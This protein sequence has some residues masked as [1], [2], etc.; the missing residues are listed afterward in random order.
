[1]TAEPKKLSKKQAKVLKALEKGKTP[2]QVATSMKINVNGVYQHM[3]RLEEKGYDV[4][5][6]GRGNT[7]RRAAPEKD[8]IDELL[9]AAPKVESNGHDARDL[10]RKGIVEVIQI[11]SDR[12]K[13]L[14]VEIT[15]LHAKKVDLEQQ[16]ERI[17]DELTKLGGIGIDLT[18]R[19]TD[20]EEI[21]AK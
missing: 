18:S 21:L 6:V 11:A 4:P 9:A 14:E 3:R 16:V 1:M 5:R 2:A 7:T 19:R 10:V 15:E 8:A 17:E 20:L 12:E 13:S